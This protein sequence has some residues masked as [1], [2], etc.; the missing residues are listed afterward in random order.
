MG[1][2]FLT[3]LDGVGLAKIMRI[4]SRWTVLVESSDPG[5]RRFRCSFLVAV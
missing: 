1:F 3:P 5:E 4:C 2:I